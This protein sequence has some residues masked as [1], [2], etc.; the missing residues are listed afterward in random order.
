M[1]RF[2]T[3]LLTLALIFSL[4]ACGNSAKPLSASKETADTVQEPESQKSDSYTGNAKEWKKFLKDYE[5]WVDKYVEFLDKYADNKDD[6]EYWSDYAK[7]MKEMTDWQTR[8]EKVQKELENASPAEVAEYSAELMKI[9]AK[10]SEK[11]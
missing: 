6:S 11:Q 4:G 9:V 2:L 7:L 10:L 5:N 1:K 3:I 8:A